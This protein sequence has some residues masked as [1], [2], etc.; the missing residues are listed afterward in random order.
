MF[1]YYDSVGTALTAA[2][3]NSPKVARVRISVRGQA[4]QVNVSGMPEGTYNDSLVM[5]VGLRNQQ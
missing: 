4:Q 5:D 1:S 3:A 2:T